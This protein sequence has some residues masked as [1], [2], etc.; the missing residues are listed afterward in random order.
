MIIIHVSLGIN[1]E[2]L[3]KKKLVDW[4]VC[5]CRNNYELLLG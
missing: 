2:V 4:Y 5:A 1:D 3:M